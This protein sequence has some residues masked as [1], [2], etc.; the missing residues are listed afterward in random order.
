M[1]NDILSIEENK[2]LQGEDVYDVY[3]IFENTESCIEF[4]HEKTNI[5]KCDIKL[6][7]EKESKDYLFV[8]NL[9]DYY[10]VKIAH[11]NYIG[12]RTGRIAIVEFY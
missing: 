3:K 8:N 4:I 7:F 2:A 11:V 10:N 12:F 6:E 9:E 1:F 5:S